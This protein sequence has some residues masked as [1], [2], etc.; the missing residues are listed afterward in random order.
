[1]YFLNAFNGNPAIRSDTLKSPKKP[2]P[3]RK[4]LKFCSKGPWPPFFAIFVATIFVFV[5][6]DAL[7]RLEFEIADQFTFIL[8]HETSHTASVISIQNVIQLEVSYQ[9]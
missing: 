4:I 6:H 5:V 2:C 3:I 9:V 7:I 1:M 8:D